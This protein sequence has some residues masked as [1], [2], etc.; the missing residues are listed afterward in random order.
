METV[1]CPY[2]NGNPGSADYD[3]AAPYC[4]VSDVDLSER[5]R[6]DCPLWEP[7]Q[8]IEKANL[9]PAIAEAPTSGRSKDHAT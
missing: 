8:S 7:K 1:Y 9:T 2:H 3:V 4:D 5:K 6:S